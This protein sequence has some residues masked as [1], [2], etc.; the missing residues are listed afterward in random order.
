MLQ[1]LYNLPPNG[2]AGQTVAL[3]VAFDDPAAEADLAV[4]RQTFGLPPCS[5][6]NGCFSKIAG[7]GSGTLPAPDYGWAAE[8]S[9]DLDAV[10][11]ACPQCKL[12]LVEAAS[13]QIPDLATSVDTAVAAGANEVSNSYGVAEA[14]DNVQYDS[15]YN[16]PGVPITAAAGDVGYGVQFPASS[17]YVTASPT[18][19]GTTLPTP[20]SPTPRNLRAIRWT[21]IAC[22]TCM[23]ETCCAAGASIASTFSNRSSI[24]RRRL[25][26]K[27]P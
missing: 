14:A 2:G 5:S 19:G 17:E 20:G 23:P 22:S 8:A 25:N 15:H 18:A 1:Y 11:A 27:R 26:W 9:L 21:A 16:H 24:K 13:A 4:Y 12:T 10:S 7:N 6:T 3:I